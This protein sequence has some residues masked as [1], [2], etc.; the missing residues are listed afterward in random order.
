M[1]GR[2]PLCPMFVIIEMAWRGPPQPPLSSEKWPGGDPAQPMFLEIPISS[3]K[4]I[5]FFFFFPPKSHAFNIAKKRTK[6]FSWRKKIMFLEFPNSS[7]KLIKK[8]TIFFSPLKVGFL[9]I[10]K[11]GPNL[12]GK[13]NHDFLY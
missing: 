5:I 8:I 12:L 13:K 7:R 11:K 6:I 2:G 1:A 4:M 3:R 9:N 10:A